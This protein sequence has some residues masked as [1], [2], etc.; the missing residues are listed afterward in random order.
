LFNNAGGPAQTGGIEEIYKTQQPNQRAGLPAHLAD[1]ISLGPSLRLRVVAA[2]GTAFESLEP[3]G[4]EPSP[5]EGLARGE[6]V[7][8]TFGRYGLNRG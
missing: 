8:V 1:V 7:F 6:P 2:N 4:P 3:R 5:S